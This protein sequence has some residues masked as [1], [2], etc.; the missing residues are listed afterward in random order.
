MVGGVGIRMF[1]PSC[2]AVMEILIAIVREKNYEQNN[3]EWGDCG[4][5]KCAKVRVNS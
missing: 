5:E 1:P 2:D 3:D 4:E